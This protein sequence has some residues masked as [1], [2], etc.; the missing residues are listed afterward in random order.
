M[1]CRWAAV[2]SRD[3]YGRYLNSEGYVVLNK[4]FREPTLSRGVNDDGY[5]RLNLGKNGRVLEHRWVM[6]QFL[7]RSLLPDE[8]VHHKNGVKTDNRP[9]NLEVWVGKHPKGQRVEDVVEWA[10]EML[11]RYAPERLSDTTATLTFT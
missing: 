5:V 6:E 8:T 2:R 9:E 4:Q 10:T 1:E 7:G 3:E 11:Q